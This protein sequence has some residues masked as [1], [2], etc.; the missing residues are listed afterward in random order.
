MKYLIDHQ[1]KIVHEKKYTEARCGFADTPVENRELT[2]SE[3][4]IEQL[5]HEK[6]YLKCPYCHDVYPIID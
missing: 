3:S 5:E 6:S 1:K 2:D 4:Y